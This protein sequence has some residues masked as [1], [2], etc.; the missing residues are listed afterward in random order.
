M[1]RSLGDPR[2]LTL[3]TAA[4]NSFPMTD[5]DTDPEQSV[6]ADAAFA[7]LS[8]PTRLDILRALHEYA[9]ESGEATVGFADLRKRAGVEDGGRF[10]Y[11]LNELRD[12]FVEKTDDGYRATYAGSE[13]VAAVL[14]GTYTGRD[15]LGPTELDDACGRCGGTV[16]GR[17]VRGAVDVTCENGHPLLRWTLPPN[18]ARDAT[19]VEL[20]AVA[21]ARIRHAIELALD[22]VC[23]KCYGEMRTRLETVEDENGAET[24]VFRGEC[25][26]CGAPL[27]GPAWLPLLVH[28]TAVA[29][30]H[31]HG[32]PVQDALL[33]EL[34]QVDDETTRP[35]DDGGARITV[36]LDGD[37][38]HATLDGTGAP[39]EVVTEA[40]ARRGMT[41]SG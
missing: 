20:A 18:A 8:D 28:P 11:H 1:A 33:W 5:S 30:Y 17:Y 25:A 32:R 35:L 23:V 9:R 31:D 12:Q 26:T 16:T 41:E 7:A 34:G 4:T 3:I 14:A 10:R 19:V 29:F 40:A 24:P 2:D 21:T 6:D 38:L 22:G 37:R 15:S 13:V 36:V 39:V 27:V